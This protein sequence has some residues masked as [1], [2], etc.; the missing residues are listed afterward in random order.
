MKL[1]YTITPEVMKAGASIA[2]KHRVLKKFLFVMALLGLVIAYSFIPEGIYSP[3]IVFMILLPFLTMLNRFIY[4]TRTS[5]AAFKGKPQSIECELTTT[6]DGLQIKSTTAVSS[7]SWEHFVE[8]TISPKG[9]LMYSSKNIFN[10]IPST[11]IV[12]GGTWMDFTQLLESKIE[13]KV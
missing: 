12:T 7:V 11:A 6:M 2:Y 4:L 10:F 13:K 3:L 1:K 5:K 9:A 8:T